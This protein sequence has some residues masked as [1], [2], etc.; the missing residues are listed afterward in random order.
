MILNVGCGG[1]PGDMRAGYGDVRIDIEAFP[2]VTHV[3]DV[4]DLPP[5]WDGRFDEVVCEIAL[6]HFESPIVA[7]RNMARVMKPQGRLIIVVPNLYFWRR[8]WKNWKPNYDAMRAPT[9][10]P[11]HNQAWDVIEIRNLTIQC[12]LT[13]ISH[14]YLDWAPGRKRSP[15]TV[16]GKLLYR[17]LPHFMT[18]T[19]VRFT[20]IARDG[21]MK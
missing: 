9:S 6:E 19:E 11:S 3:L 8:I 16:L 4:H 21:V 14:D 7:M 18:T 12:G 13:I 2:N 15:G 1:R 20:L 5:E 10:H 17:C